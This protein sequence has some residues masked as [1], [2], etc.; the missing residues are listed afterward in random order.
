MRITRN[1]VRHGSV[2]PEAMAVIASVP[3]SLLHHV[4][5]RRRH[6]VSLYSKSLD[7]I[8]KAWSEVLDRID[9]FTTEFIWT[10]ADDKLPAVLEA[11]RALLVLL[12][13]HL[14]VS[15]GCLRALVPSLGTN[16]PLF[17]TQ[18]LDRARVPGWKQFRQRVQPYTQN[19]IGVVVNSLKHN[20][21]ELASFYLH[22]LPNLRAGYYVRDVL[23]SGAL[24]PA[25]R[26][27]L[28]GNS[29]F[30]FSRDMLIHFWNLYFLSGE[31]ATLMR[32]LLPNGHTANIA[33]EIA[34]D[35][36]LLAGRIANLPLAFFPDELK[37]PCPLVRWNP[38]SRELT[39]DMPGT[40]R[41][42]RLPTEY[43]MTAA[44]YIDMAHAANKMPY[45]GANGA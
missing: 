37:Q 3:D 45:F 34:S 19:R 29:A 39:I 38:S 6:P 12:Y 8:V 40:V 28:D 36:E 4:A 22:K 43:E 5:H 33:Q 32:G 41:L 42:R 2:A 13:E 20:Q 26:V 35:W 18:F 31:L 44:I 17:D 21:S 15:Y 24:G 11:Y 16:D 27:H 1:A 9:S 30:S 25:P 14:D 10:K 23:P 7:Q